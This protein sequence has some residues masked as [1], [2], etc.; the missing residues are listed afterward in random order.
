MFAS[1]FYKLLTWSASPVVLN[2][3]ALLDLLTAVSSL[4][5]VYTVMMLLFLGFTIIVPVGPETGLN[6]NEMRVMIRIK[7]TAASTFVQQNLIT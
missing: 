3:P 2:V 4:Q 5:T 7:H 1:L 6:V